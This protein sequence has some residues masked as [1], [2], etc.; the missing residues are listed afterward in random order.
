[1]QQYA[2]DLLNATAR[3]PLSGPEW[4]PDLHDAAPLAAFARQYDAGDAA[5]RCWLR[6]DLVALH[7]DIS[8][9][10]LLAAGQHG[11]TPGQADQILDSLRPLFDS[12]GL[13]LLRGQHEGAHERWYVSARQDLPAA[14]PAPMNALGQP[15]EDILRPSGKATA[16]WQRLQSETQ[17]LLHEH[18]VN[19]S[20]QAAGYLPLN[21]LWFWGAGRL[22]ERPPPQLPDAVLAISAELG[23]WCDWAQVP[24]DGKTAAAEWLQKTLSSNHKLL[25][26]WR[27]DRQTSLE[28][29]L[30]TLNGLVTVL[31]A[32]TPACARSVYCRAGK[33]QAINRPGWR[34]W[35]ASSGKVRRRGL[36]QLAALV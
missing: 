29:N 33:A 10:H 7:P 36:Q 4:L 21:S 23:G 32:Q 1:M 14:F 17:M 22:P 27:I 2:P 5:G 13:A 19:Q 9:V 12:E 16:L 18:P 3:Q 20:R 24:V 35:L 28:D 25:I 11:L 26:E 34:R 6:A 15:L 8:R 30:L 31:I